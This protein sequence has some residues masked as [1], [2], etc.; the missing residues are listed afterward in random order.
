MSLVVVFLYF[1]FSTLR[2]LYWIW[3]WNSIFGWKKYSLEC[4]GFFFKFLSGFCRIEKKEQTNN[5]IYI[6]IYICVNILNYL[7][8]HRELTRLFFL[9]FFVTFCK[10][11]WQ[12]ELNLKSICILQK[13]ICHIH[14]QNVT[15]KWQI[16]WRVS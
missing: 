5:N 14:L 3:V 4:T 6:I 10:Q 7:L 12:T 11:M 13:Q 15:K 1:L 8:I 2:Y 9:T 16:Y